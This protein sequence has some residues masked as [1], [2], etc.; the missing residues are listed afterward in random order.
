ML[1]DVT[2]VLSMLG[3]GL[4]CQLLQVRGAGRAEFLGTRIGF[5]PLTSTPQASLPISGG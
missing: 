3:S 2:D 1:T 5:I 4:E